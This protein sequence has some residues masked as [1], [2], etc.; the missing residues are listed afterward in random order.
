MNDF[1]NEPTTTKPLFLVWLKLQSAFFFRARISRFCM[2][3]TRK[4]ARFFS[5]TLGSA[6]PGKT[7]AV[8][9]G[10]LP[11]L[12]GCHRLSGYFPYLIEIQ[13]PIG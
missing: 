1:L 11:T 2:K 12:I 6:I 9:T 10:K 7:I 3:N 5:V 8:E 4:L 13:L